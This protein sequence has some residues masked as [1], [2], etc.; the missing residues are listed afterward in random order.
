MMQLADQASDDGE[1]KPTR[2]GERE[3]SLTECAS[4]RDLATTDGGL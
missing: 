3:S 2:A 4:P 1:R